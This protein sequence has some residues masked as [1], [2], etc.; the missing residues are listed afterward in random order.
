MFAINTDIDQ[1]L[2][3]KNNGYSF[4]YLPNFVQDAFYWQNVNEAVRE[5]KQCIFQA[6][7]LYNIMKSLDGGDHSDYE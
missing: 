2:L 5:F 6:S 1:P 4:F 3:K 7:R